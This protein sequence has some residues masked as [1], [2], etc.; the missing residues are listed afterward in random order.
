LQIGIPSFLYSG[1]IC[2]MV[3]WLY[4]HEEI[5]DEFREKLMAFVGSLKVGDGTEADVF[6][7][8]VQNSMQYDKAKNLFGSLSKEGLTTA[9][10]GNI[11]DSAGYF[12]T[13]PSSITLRSHRG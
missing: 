1:Q 5:Y 12:T 6:V 9:L 7:G 2:M 10:C 11:Q 4:V 8:H 13:R 3:K